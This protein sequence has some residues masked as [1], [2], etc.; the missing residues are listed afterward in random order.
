MSSL[1]RAVGISCFYGGSPKRRGGSV[2][3]RGKG[4]STDL[5]GNTIL[6]LDEDDAN[7]RII[8]EEAVFD[9]GNWLA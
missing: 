2:F 5:G 3:R 1:V 9:S 8:G 6:N 7:R 4:Y